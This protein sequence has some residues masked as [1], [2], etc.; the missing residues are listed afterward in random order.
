MNQGLYTAVGAM[1]SAEQRIEFTAHNLANLGTPGFK[2]RSSSSG[3]FRI[4]TDTG[5]QRA[6]GTGA[7]QDFEQGAFQR[8]NSAMHVALEGRGFLSVEG[9]D[10][11]IYTRRGELVMDGD[12]ELKTEDGLPLAWA[13]RLGSFD[14]LGDELT[15]EPDGEVHQGEIRLGRLKLSDFEDYSQLTELTD[16][17]WAAGERAKTTNAA[18]SLRQGELEASN[19][20]GIDE[21]VELIANQRFYE[22]AN[23]AVKSIDQS[24]QR[25]N[26]QG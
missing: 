19:A 20:T 17:Y 5:E 13:E 6:V 15:I 4:L 10:G 11:E 16:G 8:T 14:A 12:S 7:I 24:Y 22:L 18:A 9:P 23:R 2:R 21:M 25:L 3:E 26:R 1:R